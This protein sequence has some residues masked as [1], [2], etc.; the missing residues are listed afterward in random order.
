[1]ADKPSGGAS[2]TPYSV[3]PSAASP[4]YGTCCATARDF[5]V[6]G[7]LMDDRYSVRWSAIGDPTDWPTPAT[8]DARTKQS[9]EQSFPTKHGWVTGLAGNDF[10][11]YVF[12]EKAISKATYVGGDVVWTF[13]T[14]EEDRGC[15]RQGRVLQVDDYVFFE[16]DRGRHAL[17]N[18][19]IED[20]GF[21]I[22]DDSY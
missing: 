2:S 11:F 22:T 6:L 20:I 19:Q 16:S 1:M 18:D 15:V 7:G 17:L 5:V 14:F 13:D 4:I 8:D 21:G 9:G 12:Q 3:V 10:Y